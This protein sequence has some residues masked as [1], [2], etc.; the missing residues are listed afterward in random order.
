MGR[1][2]LVLCLLLAFATVWSASVA[3]EAERDALESM[4][5]NQLYRAGLEAF[6][7]GDID[8]SCRAFDLQLERRPVDRPAMWQR[9]ISLYYAHRL[10]ECVAQFESHRTENPHDAE[11]AA[12]HYLCVAALKGE[13]KARARLL[14]ARDGRIPMM[15]VHRLYA[16][17]ATVD[18]V[19]AAAAKGGRSGQFYA[20]L[21]VALWRESR[22]EAKEARHHLEQALDGPSIKHYMEVVARVHLERIR[23][24]EHWATKP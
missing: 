17:E 9:G 5:A 21:Y 8:L 1:P 20:H 15:A 22:G 23:N 7:A 19:F 14:P 2:G 10:K 11:N 13:S 3:S 12:W 6:A 24:S 16:G 4:T 18:E